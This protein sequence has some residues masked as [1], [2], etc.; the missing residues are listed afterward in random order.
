MQITYHKY[1][2]QRYFSYKTRLRI[3]KY[4]HFCFR[5][6]DKA[7]CDNLRLAL[8]PIGHCP[9]KADLRLRLGHL[10]VGELQH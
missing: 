2:A 1:P 3:K 10:R 5:F 7:D 4:G 6:S 8:T 9:V